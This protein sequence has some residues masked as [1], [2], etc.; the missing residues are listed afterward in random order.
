MY[1]EGEKPLFMSVLIDNH[2]IDS[3]DVFVDE[4]SLVVYESVDD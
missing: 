1:E 4:S 2:P 3:V